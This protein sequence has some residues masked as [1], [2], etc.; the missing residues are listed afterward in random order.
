MT[1]LP[2]PQEKTG[3]TDKQKRPERKIIKPKLVK[4]VEP[5]YPDEAKKDGLEGAVVVGGVTDENGKVVKI[6]IIRGEHKLLNNAVID[7]VKQ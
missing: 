6:K 2:T 4:K 3:K 1:P 5:V 7:A